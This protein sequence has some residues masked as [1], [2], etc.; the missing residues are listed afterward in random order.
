MAHALELDPAC[1]IAYRMWGM[2]LA[3]QRRLDEALAALRRAQSLEPLAV[4]INGN[5]GMAYYFAG[6]FEDA[7]VQ[8]EHTLRMDGNWAV[9]QS[10]L[11]RSYLCLGQFERALELF[12]GDGMSWG[13]APDRAI[14]YALS[15]RIGDA[16]RELARLSQ[17][18]EGE[19][20]PP[21]HFVTMYAALGDH[22]AAL[23]WVDRVIEARVNTGF[24]VFEP[25]LHG[26]RKDPR[27]IERLERTALGPLL[28]R[29]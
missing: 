28:A 23:D 15:G 25:L 19:Y 26:L 7:I 29:P 16:R 5:I 4:H 27:V 24:L 21:I 13:R 20:V 8:L 2:H 3:G 14:A 10:T 9:A 12:D 22:D 18:P 11:G 6:R 1:F 17:R